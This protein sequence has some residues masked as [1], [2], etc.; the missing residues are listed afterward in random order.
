MPLTATPFCRQNMSVTVETCACTRCDSLLRLTAP[1][2]AMYRKDQHESFQLSYNQTPHL[3]STRAQRILC[4]GGAI[5]QPA[6]RDFHGV[7]ALLGA[8][9]EPQAHAH[10][11][12]GADAEGSNTRKRSVVSQA[13]SHHQWQA[14]P[15]TL[16]Q[17]AV[18]T[19]SFV[20]INLAALS[21]GNLQT[22]NCHL[23]TCKNLAALL[24]L[25]CDHLS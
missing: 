21:L 10:C 18:F 9:P 2:R 13:G 5:A 22:C 12:S 24:H 1:V 11:G 6:A 20:L 3:K 17:G 16:R 14:L 15:W 4:A 25:R 23:E 19:K 7:E 8:I